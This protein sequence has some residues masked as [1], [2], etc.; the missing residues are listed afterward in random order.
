LFPSLRFILNNANVA[1]ATAALPST[2]APTTWLTAE[3]LPSTAR[4]MNFRV[5]A[6]DNR[7]GGGGTNEASVA[8]TTATA[9]GPFIV[10]APNT[11]VSWAEGDSQ[12]IKWMSRVPTPMA[13]M[14]R[15]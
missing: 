8:V 9:A 6:R 12:T 3:V 5:T 7:A 14:P 1:P 13:L 15:Q 11:A 2:T 10:T 4:T